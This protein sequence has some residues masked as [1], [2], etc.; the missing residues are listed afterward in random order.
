VRIVTAL[1]QERLDALAARLRE[2]KIWELSEL[3]SQQAEPDAREI[4]ISFRFDGARIAGSYPL[5]LAAKQRVLAALREEMQSLVDSALAVS[6]REQKAA[7]DVAW[8]ETVQE[9]R[10]RLRAERTTGT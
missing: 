9:V 8:G 5:P 3:A 4:Y 1:P 2:I 7:A 6:E 10:V